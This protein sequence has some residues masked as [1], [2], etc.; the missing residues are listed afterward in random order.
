M[1]LLRSAQPVDWFVLGVGVLLSFMTA[2]ACIHYFLSFIERVGMLPFVIYRLL[3]G[4]GLLFV[5]YL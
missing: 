4:T 3:L 5:L 2:Y 1:D